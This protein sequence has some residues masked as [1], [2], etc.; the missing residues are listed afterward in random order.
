VPKEWRLNR[1]IGSAH[2]DGDF[3]DVGSSDW[4]EALRRALAPLL[5]QLGIPDFDAS[6]LQ[7]SAPRLLTQR[8]SAITY[9]K[10]AHGIRYLS[11]YGHD[12][13]NWALFEPAQLRCEP[14]SLILPD[15]P[16]LCVALDLFNLKLEQPL[17]K[18]PDMTMQPETISPEEPFSPE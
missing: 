4:I 16:D 2:V 6:A 12:I 11:K 9:E 13:V 8:V 3:A 14:D 7:R 1:L 18:T 17:A 5:I 10:G 15:D